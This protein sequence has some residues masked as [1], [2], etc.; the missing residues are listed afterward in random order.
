MDFEMKCCQKHTPILL[1]EQFA[2]RKLKNPRSSSCTLHALS[3]VS[4]LDIRQGGLAPKKFRTTRLSRL[5]I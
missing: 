1:S 5:A 2:V 3:D 4:R